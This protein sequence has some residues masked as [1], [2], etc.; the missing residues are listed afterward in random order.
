METALYTELWALWWIIPWTQLSP[1][2][3]LCL[4]SLFLPACCIFFR[5]SS[6]FPSLS[7][8]ICICGNRTCLCA[9][10]S[11]TQVPLDVNTLSPH[12]ASKTFGWTVNHWNKSQNWQWWSWVTPNNKDGEMLESPWSV[13][14]VHVALSIWNGLPHDYQALF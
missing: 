1:F 13:H 6:A 3:L 4:S 10:Y 12:V 7:K 14:S 2:R 9:S 8:A 5:S 11:L